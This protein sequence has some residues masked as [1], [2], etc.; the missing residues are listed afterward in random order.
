MA[1]SASDHN[2][3]PAGGRVLKEDWANPEL[4]C[5]GRSQGMMPTRTHVRTS[6]DAVRWC[7]RPAGTWSGVNDEVCLQLR[8]PESRACGD[9]RRCC[10]ASA[11][12]WDSCR[13]FMWGSSGLYV[14]MLLLSGSGI[15]MNGLFSFLAPSTTTPLPVRRERRRA[16]LRVQPLV[17]GPQR[18]LAAQRRPA[19]PLQHD[20]GAA[21][22]PGVRR[23]LRR[24]PHGH[25]LHRGRASW[26]SPP[27][28]SRGCSSAGFPILGGAGFTV[29]ASAPVFGLLGAVVLYGQRSGSSMARR[30]G[31]Q[32]A[33]TMG[34][35]GLIMPGI[36]NWAHAGGFAGGWLMARILDPLK[37]ERLDHLAIA[38]GL[39]A[40][41]AGRHRRVHRPRL[42]A[43]RRGAV[44]G[45]LRH[46]DNTGS[47]W[48]QPS[49]PP[50]R[51]SI[52]SRIPSPGYFT[53]F[54]IA[55][56]KSQ[57]PSRPCRCRIF[58]SGECTPSS[59]GPNDTMSMPGY[60][61]PMM[62]HS[63]PAWTAFTSGSLP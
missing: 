62:P 61:S 19:H 45:R 21:A 6:N 25:H 4:G 18:R 29:G 32:Y 58:S 39:R 14:A 49:P 7:A 55:S 54:R 17:D 38:V 40:A 57:V 52:E 23:A 22:R 46:R 47:G 33:L 20:V 13:S 2:L 3:G 8:A 50:S 15:R 28:R 5:P 44:D 63:S 37:P 24:R 53:F 41:D 10:A 26:G 27:V 42:L 56:R 9:S 1:P 51:I 48:P 43:V 60:F 34:L 31:L 35:F 59:V 30:E 12:T 11:T 16:G 36:D